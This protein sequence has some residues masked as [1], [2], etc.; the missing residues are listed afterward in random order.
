MNA[1]PA[2]LDA[3][4]DYKDRSCG[5]R[6][7]TRELSDPEFIELRGLRGMEGWLLFG[8]EQPTKSDIPKGTPETGG[9]SQAQR[10]A[11]V[12]YRLWEQGG[13]EDG[14]GM[15]DREWYQTKMEAIITKLKNALE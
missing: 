10:L 4:N 6:F 14:T 1:L 13:R 2:I 3:V 8:N 15:N 11:G 9:K 7:V 5:L 12:L